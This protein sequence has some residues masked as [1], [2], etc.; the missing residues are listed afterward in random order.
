M[1]KAI[2]VVIIIES[3]PLSN[4]EE[5]KIE[6]ESNDLEGSFDF[7]EKTP[8]L[9]ISNGGEHLLQYEPIEEINFP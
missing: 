7:Y 2:N 4:N 1:K 8:S 9:V 6:I 5:N 3:C